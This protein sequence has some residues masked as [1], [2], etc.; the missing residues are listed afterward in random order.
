[1]FSSIGQDAR[2]LG[3]DIRCVGLISCLGILSWIKDD[4]DDGEAIL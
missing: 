2:S 4:S 3:F 1:M